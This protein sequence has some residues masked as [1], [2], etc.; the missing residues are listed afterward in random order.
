MMK[1]SIKSGIFAGSV[2]Q[3]VDF[4]VEMTS[5]LFSFITL[6]NSLPLVVMSRGPYP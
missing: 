3:Y 2:G 5:H 6:S 4:P 1:K